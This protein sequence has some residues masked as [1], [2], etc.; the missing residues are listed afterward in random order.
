M[1][2]PGSLY[3]SHSTLRSL[4]L[5]DGHRCEMDCR[6]RSSTKRRSSLNGVML[7][8][9]VVGPLCHTA[10]NDSLRFLHLQLS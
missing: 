10:F 4:P 7:F 6:K 2:V 3:R 1:I 9:A 5:P 8:S